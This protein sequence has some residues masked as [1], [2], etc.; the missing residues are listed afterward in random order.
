[1]SNV[2]EAAYA[3][4]KAARALACASSE[5]KNN[6]LGLIADALVLNTAKILGANALDVASA[7]E[8]GMSVSLID[9]L[10]LSEG[11]ISEMAQGVREV[12]KLCDPIGEII[13]HISR[14]N[15]LEIDKVRVPIGV[16]GMIYEARP[17]V[18]VDSAALAL[19][20]GNAIILRGSASAL[21]S[22]TVLA[23]IMRGALNKS[24][25]PEDAVNLITDTSH[26]GAEEMMRMT[27]A[28]DLLIPRGGASLI[29]SVVEKAKVP[30]IR[31]GVGN[32]H[33]YL[34]SSADREMAIKLIINSKAQRPSTCNAAETLL[35]S[36]NYPDIPSIL[37]AISES[38]IKIHGC[39]K[40]CNMCSYAVPACEEDYECEYLSL[41]ICVKIVKG[42]D[43]AIDH[44]AR[45]GTGHTEL[46]I[47]D[48]KENAEKFMNET[49]AASVN[50]NASTRFTDGGQ[51]GFG[52]EIGIATQ[53]LHAR[54]PLGLHELTIYKY[55]VYGNGEVRK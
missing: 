52:A 28:I 49:D 30:V 19:K 17:N 46:I 53:K 41:D 20:S 39:E 43:E 21:R 47:T 48:S 10:T 34:D 3:A 15:G 42:I 24:R 38:G 55:K 26:E 18:T 29:N 11:R 54:G 35:I 33:I 7:K 14:P 44:I 37:A 8:K 12:A 16:I 23:D 25:I 45:Y 51:F 50:H 1:M 32:C 6:A 40:I 31:T 36:E 4:K 13:E 27:E 2:R 9:R 22:N 5:D